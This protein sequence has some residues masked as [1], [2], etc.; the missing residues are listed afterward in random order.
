MKKIL[1]I[2]AACLSAIAVGYYIFTLKQKVERKFDILDEQLAILDSTNAAEE[3]IDSMHMPL[4][5]RQEKSLFVGSEQTDSMKLICSIEVKT[6]NPKSF[7]YT[8]DFMND[9]KKFK[10]IKGTAF[11]VSSGNYQMKDAHTDKEIAA[12]KFVDIKNNLAIEIS[13]QDLSSSIARV[14]KFL[15]N[16]AELTPVMFYK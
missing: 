9:S 5:L 2:G 14:K 13:N 15:G 10:T 8:L 16:D 3:A 6:I 11:N 1:I 7:E 4:V 12:C